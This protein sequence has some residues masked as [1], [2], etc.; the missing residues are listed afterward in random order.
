M[1]ARLEQLVLVFRLI[2]KTA[3]PVGGSNKTL[4][5][6]KSSPANISVLP[7]T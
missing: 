5:V 3:F 2:L 6:W 4:S 7:D 1:I